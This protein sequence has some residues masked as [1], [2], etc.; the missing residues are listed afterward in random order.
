MDNASPIESL[1][2]LRNAAEQGDP[3]AQYDLAIIYAG[4]RGVPK[5]TAE[6][7]Q[8]FRKAAGQGHAPAQYELGLCF[9]HGRGVPKD[10]AEAVKWFRKAAE[11]GNVSAQL[12]L[13][14]AY[15][16]GKGIEKDQEESLRWLRKAAEAGDARAQHRLGLEY[17]LGRM[18]PRDFAEAAKWVR[19]AAEAGHVDA[20]SSY[21]GFLRYGWGV[22]KNL[23]EAVEWYRKAA[24]Q[25]D[26]HGEYHLGMC[27]AY[28]WLGIGKDFEEARKWLQLAAEKNYRDAKYQ[29]Q[30]L[31]FRKHPILI[32][33][34][35]S[36]TICGLGLLIFH[37]IRSPILIQIHAVG[38][39]FGI[40]A[41]V[42][43]IA[44]AIIFVLKKLGIKG[45][46]NE[47]MEQWNK[48]F[49]S[50]VKKRPWQFLLIP[51]EDGFFLLPLLYI[52]INPVSAAVAAF[53]FGVTHYPMF[54]WHTCIPK[55]VA[56]FFVALFVLP[57]G[58]WSI[59]V[60]HWLLDA[61]ALLWVLLAEVKG[62]PTLRRILEAW[63][64]E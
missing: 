64:T 56:Y 7:T 35:I 46:D 58:I 34:N 62:K 12:L 42:T 20:Q 15:K 9:K 4:G 49:F 54:P 5:D 21:G 25:G 19:K 16:C 57:Y 30:L 38:A 45:L 22:E 50:A 6:A 51:A 55:C 36:T 24:V 52:G 14:I 33:L 32:W 29:L 63:K 48:R 23:A 44:L 2:E 17:F 26:K 53:L 37:G 8:W 61:L 40:F 39:Y 18:M 13:S 1:D 11:L 31:F 27:Y 60:A 43:S 10:E 59:V 47:E 28:G 41:V 3:L